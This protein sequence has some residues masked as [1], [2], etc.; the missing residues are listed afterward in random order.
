MPLP[1]AVEIATKD[2]AAAEVSR[3]DYSEQTPTDL[4]LLARYRFQ[5]DLRIT[6]SVTIAGVIFFNGQSM[7]LPDAIALEK[8]FFLE[9]ARA[10]WQRGRDA[11]QKAKEQA[12][13]REQERIEFEKG[14]SQWRFLSELKVALTRV[15]D[16]HRGGCKLVRELQDAEAEKAKLGADETSDLSKLQKQLGTCNN[17]IEALEQRIRHTEGEYKKALENLKE[18]AILARREAAFQQ[19]RAK[20]PLLAAALGAIKTILSLSDSDARELSSRN[21]GMLALNNVCSIGEGMRAYD[22][23]A[24]AFAQET[25]KRC[26]GLKTFLADNYNAYLSR[27]KGLAGQ[28]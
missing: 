3:G 22:T 18:C 11:R 23:P 25:L 8:K 7:A 20:A 28:A 19:D 12:E 21:H 26:A 4:E 5:S 13:Q 17:T 6:P 10:R 9:N 24:L 1:S 15:E 16:L 14:A 2:S 27:L